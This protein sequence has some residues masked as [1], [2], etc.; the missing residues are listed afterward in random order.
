MYDQG[1]AA[2][3]AY[4][5]GDRLDQAGGQELQTGGGADGALGRAGVE[6]EGVAAGGEVLTV[7][8]DER[9]LGEDLRG[10]ALGGARGG[11]RGGQVHAEVEP[12]EQDLQHGG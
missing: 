3:A 8:V 11:E 2:A 5:F 1:G 10:V 12:V 6:L 9:L 7:L 4:G